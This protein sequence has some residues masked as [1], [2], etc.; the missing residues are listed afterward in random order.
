M[1]ANSD[2]DDKETCSDGMSSGATH[3]QRLKGTAA[4]YEA[5]FYVDESLRREASVRTPWS[6]VTDDT[7][8]VVSIPGG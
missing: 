5:R 2:M 7:A 8:T 3:G 4:G 1:P 6:G